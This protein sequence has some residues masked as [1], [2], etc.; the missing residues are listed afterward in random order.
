MAG[1]LEGHAGGILGLD[2]LLDEHG[3]AVEYDLIALG[4]R[5]DDLGTERLTWRDLWVIVQHS[6]RESAIARAVGAEEAVWSLTDHLLATVIDVLNIANWQRENAGRP[7]GKS[8][9]RR[10]KRIPRPGVEGEHKTVGSEPIPIKDFEAWWDAGVVDAA[11]G[12]ETT[13]VTGG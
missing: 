13:G 11:P 7:R 8:P 2:Q 3:G 6:P 4:L 5:L 9:T 12:Q 1:G 10:P